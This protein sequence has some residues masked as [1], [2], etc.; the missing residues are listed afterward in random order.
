MIRLFKINTWLYAFSYEGMQYMK[1]HTGSVR[2]R[3][4]TIV[5]SSVA[6]CC[7]VLFVV[8]IAP[9]RPAPERAFD[10]YNDFAREMS[11]TGFWIPP[12]ELL[13][14][15]AIYGVIYDGRTLAAS[16]CRYYIYDSASCVEIGASRQSDSAFL[17]DHDRG[18]PFEYNGSTCVWQ[19][20]I[21]HR[22][23]GSWREN[24]TTYKLIFDLIACFEAP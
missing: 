17:G 19:G 5:I 21:L 13:P 12:K 6:L 16:P 20:D 11:H 4:A 18:V 2:K 24:D 7:L 22:I 8:C 1:I 15:S 9:I 10:S 23:S 3:L 14:E